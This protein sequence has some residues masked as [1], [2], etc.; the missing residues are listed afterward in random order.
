MAEVS[1]V[2]DCI[3]IAFLTEKVFAQITR[4][5]ESKDLAESKEIGKEKITRI[6]TYTNTVVIFVCMG[7][8]PK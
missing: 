8:Y 5:S 6:E 1:V 4:V 7:S 3:L 2:T